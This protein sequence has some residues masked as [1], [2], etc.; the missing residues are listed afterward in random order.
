MLTAGTVY[1]ITVISLYKKGKKIVTGRQQVLKNAYTLPSAPKATSVKKGKARR[2]KVYW[3]KVSGV[4]GYEVQ[5]STRKKSG[6][7]TIKAVNAKTSAYTVSKLK[8]NKRYYFR[9][10]SFKSDRRKEG[11]Q[12]LVKR[13]DRKSKVTQLKYS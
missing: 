9:I 11:L 7:K 10:R 3:K 12:Y 8:K 5:M 4:Q 1:K 2:L 13:S 6:Y